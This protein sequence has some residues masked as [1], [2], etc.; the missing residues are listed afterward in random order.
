MISNY[1]PLESVKIDYN[2][3]PNGA[4]ISMVVNGNTVQESYVLGEN[5][6]IPSNLQKTQGSAAIFAIEKVVLAYLG[7]DLR[8]PEWRRE[9]GRSPSGTIDT[10]WVKLIKSD[11]TEYEGIGLYSSDNPWHE[12]YVAAIN[13]MLGEKSQ[14]E[15]IKE[16]VA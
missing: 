7:I 5:P 14:A 15:K 8:S 3:R 16:R 4:D 1:K 11:G 12:A 9:N 2:R 13:K 10:V 6:N